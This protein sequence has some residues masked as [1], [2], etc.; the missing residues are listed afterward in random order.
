MKIPHLRNLYKKVGMDMFHTSSNAGFGYGHD[1]TIDTISRFLNMPE[2]Q[3]NNDQETSDGTAFMLSFSGSALPVAN[4]T[5]ML[6]PPGV[7][8]KDVPASV[9]TQLTLSGTPD[10][11]Q[12]ALLT[13]MYAQA[14]LGKVGLIVTGRVAGEQRGFTY[15]GSSTWQSDRAGEQLTNAQVQ[16]LAAPGNEITYSVVPKG[17]ESRLGTDRDVDGCLNGDEGISC[18]CLSDFNEDSFVT[19]DDFDA[20]MD[21]FFLGDI[22]ADMNGDTFVTGDDFDLF[23]EKFEAGC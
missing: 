17:S 18:S 16:A 15:V 1:G 14:N 20:F 22:S 5:I 4:I 3:L 13:A 8:S 2:F 9:G 23:T 6:E 11:G 21:A 19:G 10:A 12:S 7:L